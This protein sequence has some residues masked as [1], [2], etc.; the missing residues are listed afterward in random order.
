[1]EEPTSSPEIALPRDRRDLRREKI[2][3]RQALPT[4]VRQQAEVIIHSCLWTLLSAR[5]AGTIGFCW[6]VRSEVDC[7]PFIHRLLAHGWRAGLPVVVD[8][9][10]P[11]T[12]RAWRP[13]SPMTH[14]RYGIPVPVEGDPVTLDVVLVPLVGFDGRGFRLGYGGGFF[15]RTL[16]ALAPRPLAVGVG[17]DLGRLEDLPAEDHDIPMDVIV[18]ESGILQ[19]QPPAAKG[20]SFLASAFSGRTG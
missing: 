10:C 4:A 5:P 1:M 18:T 9:A 17:F 11:M 14:D 20:R 13:E 16:A 12:F 7:L 6:P 19:P 8:V 3:A 15:D 2:M